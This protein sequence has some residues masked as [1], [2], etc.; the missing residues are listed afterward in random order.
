MNGAKLRVCFTIFMVL[1][2]LA[3]CCD[4]VVQAVE[5]SLGKPKLVVILVQTLG[6][7]ERAW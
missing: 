2:I 3:F 4:A 6:C 5:E 7:V 1:Q